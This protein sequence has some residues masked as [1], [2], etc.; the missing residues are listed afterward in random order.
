MLKCSLAAKPSLAPVL[1][2]AIDSTR[3]WTFELASELVQLG[4]GAGLADPKKSLATGGSLWVS[5][6]DLMTQV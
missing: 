2:R 6:L 5:A 3:K 1:L 4:A